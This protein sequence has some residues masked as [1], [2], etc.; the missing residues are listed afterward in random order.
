MGFLFSSP[1]PPA[2]PPPPPPVTRE[3]PEIEKRRKQVM[4]AAKRRRGRLG[5]MFA[6]ELTDQPSISQPTLGTSGKLGAF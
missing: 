3:D 6:G 4:I 2:P 1:K 5:S